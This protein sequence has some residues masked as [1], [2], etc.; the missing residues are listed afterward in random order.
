M[1]FSL[2]PS[3]GYF[4]LDPDAKT[5]QVLTSNFSYIGQVFTVNITASS[6]YQLYNNTFFNVSFYDPCVVASFTPATSDT[7]T[8]SLS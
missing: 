2:E 6:L 1:P 4:S 8:G 7:T 5:L 3:T